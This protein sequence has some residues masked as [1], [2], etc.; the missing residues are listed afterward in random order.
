MGSSALDIKRDRL[1][2]PYVIKS[3]VK[4]VEISE[5]VFSIISYSY[6]Y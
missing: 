1:K 6:E 3:L 5:K 2:E 4:V